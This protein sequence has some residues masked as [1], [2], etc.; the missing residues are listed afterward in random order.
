MVQLTKRVSKFT[1]K[2]FYEIDSRGCNCSHVRPFYERVVSDLGPQRS[3]HRPVW[4]AHSS[5]IEGSH[6]T[7]NTAS[8]LDLLV[9]PLWTFISSLISVILT[10]KGSAL[11]WHSYKTLFSSSTKW[12]NKLERLSLA[13]IFNL[14]QHSQHFIFFVT[15]EWAQQPSVLHY[16]KLGRTNTLAYCAD[17]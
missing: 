17:S 6:T 15:Y 2:K 11:C 9:D 7:K 12:E 4:V 14:G 10:L 16:T 5:F 3:I 13:S 1:S 8:V